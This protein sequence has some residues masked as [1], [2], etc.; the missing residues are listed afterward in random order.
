[1]LNESARAALLQAVAAGAKLP[2]EFQAAVTGQ[3]TKA[4]QDSDTTVTQKTTQQNT[5]QANNPAQTNN[6]SYVLS[7]ANKVFI[8][9]ALKGATPE[10]L[11]NV[12]IVL[13]NKLASGSV[14]QAQY[15]AIRAELKI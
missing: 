10:R 14:T 1:M 2:A 3:T 13:D 9:N 12:K 8:S 5:A 11:K 4:V 6:S 7:D 15:N